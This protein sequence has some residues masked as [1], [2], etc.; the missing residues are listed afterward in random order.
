M[1]FPAILLRLM[2]TALQLLHQTA[3]ESER[4][5]I[6]K[7]GSGEPF[8]KKV[9]EEHPMISSSDIFFISSSSLGC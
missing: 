3:V 1:V 9:K 8:G 7:P 4:G 2:V 6:K 5:D